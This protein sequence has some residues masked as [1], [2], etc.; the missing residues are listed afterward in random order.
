[1]LTIKELVNRINEQTKE[2]YEAYIKRVIGLAE[3]MMVQ[4]VATIERLRHNV[5]S[6]KW[7]IRDEMVARGEITAEKFQ[8]QYVD[9]R[10]A[11]PRDSKMTACIEALSNYEWRVSGRDLEWYRK[12]L[13]KKGKASWENQILRAATKITN[14]IQDWST[15]GFADVAEGYH[16]LE[17][18]VTFDNQYAHIRTI[19]AEGEVVKGHY[20]HICT[21]KK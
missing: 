12:D 15:L 17:I 8:E 7:G 16:G 21:L 14:N 11:L 4:Q 13:E 1:M 5:E 6:R 2:Q 3:G 9:G 19:W 20:R 18:K 10:F